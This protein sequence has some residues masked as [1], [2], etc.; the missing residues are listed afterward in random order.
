MASRIGWLSQTKATALRTKQCHR[1]REREE[2]TRGIKSGGSPVSFL[3]AAVVLH[4]QICKCETSNIFSRTGRPCAPRPWCHYCRRLPE[5]S[6]FPEL[7][8]ESRRTWKSPHL[9]WVMGQQ[10]P[11]IGHSKNLTMIYDIWNMSGSALQWLRKY[12]RR[13]ASTVVWC[14]PWFPCDDGRISFQILC[15]AV[16]KLSWSP[17]LE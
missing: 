2:E 9:S 15:D 16:T 7:Q 8:R 4:L 17:G 13:V 3:Q 5:R 1:E 14:A 6:S 12:P 11:H 10:H